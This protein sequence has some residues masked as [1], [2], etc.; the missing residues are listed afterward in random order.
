MGILSKLFGKE[1]K[2]RFEFETNEGWQVAKIRVEMFN[3]GEDELKK[4]LREMLY[5]EHGIYAKNIRILG[6]VEC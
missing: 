6:F 1:G 2:V 3:I 4:R 5:V